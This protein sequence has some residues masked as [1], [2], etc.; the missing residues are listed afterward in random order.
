VGKEEDSIGIDLEFGRPG[1]MLV[2]TF[3]HL[4]PSCIY[5]QKILDRHAATTQH[6]NAL[7]T[8]MAAMTTLGHRLCALIVVRDVGLPRNDVVRGQAYGGCKPRLAWT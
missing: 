1:K 5:T 2:A 6:R 7:F 8:S 3:G 4:N